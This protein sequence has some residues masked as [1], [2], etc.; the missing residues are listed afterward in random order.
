MAAAPVPAGS[1]ASVAAIAE[2][3]AALAD[4]A[5]A[6]R[7]GHLG[8]RTPCSRFSVAGLL[9]H[10]TYSLRSCERAARKDTAPDTRDTTDTTGA[11]GTTGATAVPD[12]P[13]GTVLPF[14]PAGAPAPAPD[15]APDLAPDPAQGRRH[16]TPPG[17]APASAR[18]VAAA[19]RRTGAAWQRPE[20]LLGTTEFG[21]VPGRGRGPEKL[22]AAF[23]VMVTVQ[24][25]GLHGWD[26]ARSIGLPFRVSQET[27]RVLVEAVGVFAARARSSG[28]YGPALDLSPNAPALLRA[29]AASGRSPSWSSRPRLRPVD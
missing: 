26:L 2:L 4:V 5:D 18:D 11:T 27:G 10:L 6:V 23:A 17:A 13:A 21:L 19:S 1:D 22:P 20:A 28:S 3:S 24:E 9:G 7:P 29:L 15:L 8:E 16:G 12:F 25:L 14:L